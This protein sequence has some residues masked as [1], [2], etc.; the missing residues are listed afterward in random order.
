MVRG[1]S[2]PSALAAKPRQKHPRSHSRCSRAAAYQGYH[3]EGVLTCL[4]RL[5]A[6]PP[7]APIPQTS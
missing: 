7:N 3:G 5:S 6:P 4:G 1:C 2:P